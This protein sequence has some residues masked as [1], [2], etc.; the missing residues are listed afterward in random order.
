M[1]VVTLRV[2]SVL[3]ATILAVLLAMLVYS[4]SASGAANFQ[5]GFAQAR[6]TGGLVQPTA[7]AV[8][9]DGRI[10]VAE[11]SGKLRVIKRDK[12][13]QRPFARFGVDS[14]GERG[15]LGVALDPKFKKNGYV[16]VY[17][18]TKKQP[19]HN[20]VIRLK[21]RGDRAT[22]QRK[23]ILRLNNLSA[24]KNHNGGA[25]H[26]GK[27]GKLYIAVGDNAEKT[28]AQTLRN[29]KGKILR[30]NRDGSIPKDNPFYKKARGKNRAIWARGLRNPYSFD[31][32][33]GTGRI[34]IN[35]VGQTAWEEINAGA[36]GANYGWPRYE[37]PE[38]D[39]RFKPPIYAYRH[40]AGPTTGCAITGGAFY[41]PQKVRF[42][43]RYVGDYF[44][45]DFC[46]GWIRRLDPR[47]RKV[48]S[49]A[50]GISNPVDL[51]VEKGGNLLYL[52]HGTG[53]VYRARF[54]GR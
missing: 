42:P 12:L 46:S 22:A 24:A 39:R 49:F 25:V 3:S 10:F 36:K 31:V 43:R 9:P 41:N 32:Q 8:A 54:T 45:A 50:S 15:L 5:N 34:F 37:G 30:V 27:D 35:D 19:V 20:R 1:K 11:Q 18:T 23:L 7:M 17:L 47:T 13:L 28:N 29:L 44:F 51:K 53:S 2:S 6:V 52:E 40:G 21:A 38:K 14:S 33:P 26:F 4:S 16:Y 48:T